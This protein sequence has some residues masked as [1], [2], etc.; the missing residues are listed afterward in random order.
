MSITFFFSRIIHFGER[1][2]SLVTIND[3][4]HFSNYQTTPGNLKYIYITKTWTKNKNTQHK[5]CV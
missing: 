4:F 5:N 2:L 3:F 1:F